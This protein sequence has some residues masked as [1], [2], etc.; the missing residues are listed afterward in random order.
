MRLLR[1]LIVIYAVVFDSEKYKETDWSTIRDQY[2]FLLR[3]D[4]TKAKLNVLGWRIA[5]PPTP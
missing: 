1:I 5:Y 4:L 2:S 3:Y